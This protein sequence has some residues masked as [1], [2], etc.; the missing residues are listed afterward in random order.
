MSDRC[1]RAHT[2]LSDGKLVS[3]ADGGS[4]FV[5]G[6]FP[7][8][9]FGHGDTEEEA[10]K[11]AIAKAKAAAA[12]FCA[13]KKC[14]RGGKCIWSDITRRFDA[15]IEYATPGMGWVAVLRIKII[16]CKCKD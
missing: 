4:T 14:K 10:R 13:K 15:V 6:D 3:N 16:E 12:E 9:I 2:L 5:P 11:D 1:D 8:L 7:E